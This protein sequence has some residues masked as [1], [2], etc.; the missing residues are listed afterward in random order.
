ML[1]KAE[2]GKDASYTMLLEGNEELDFLKLGTVE[3]RLLIVF[4]RSSW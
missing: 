1:Y 2:S 3:I 4:E